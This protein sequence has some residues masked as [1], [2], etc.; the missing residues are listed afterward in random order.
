MFSTRFHEK[1]ATS[2]NRILKLTATSNTTPMILLYNLHC[3]IEAYYI[4]FYI[5]NV[6]QKN[7][8]FSFQPFLFCFNLSTLHKQ[9]YTNIYIYIYIYIYICIYEYNQK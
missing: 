2:K 7:V 8:L 1:R 9:Y 3:R 4:K 5:N 6:S